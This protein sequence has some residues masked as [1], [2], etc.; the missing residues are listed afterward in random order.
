MRTYTAAERIKV[1]EEIIEIQNLAKK[2]LRKNGGHDIRL[3]PEG[4]DYC[5]AISNV[6]GMENRPEKR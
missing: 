2:V 1:L 4:G 5:G 3:V 6:Q